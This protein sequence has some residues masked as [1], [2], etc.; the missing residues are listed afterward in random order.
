MTPNYILYGQWP[1]A[2]NTR[3]AERQ[4]N[5]AAIAELCGVDAS[6]VR[7]WRFSNNI[8]W[9]HLPVVVLASGL[10]FDLFI[11]PALL[12][13]RGDGGTGPVM[14][15][16][17]LPRSKSRRDPLPDLLAPPPAAPRPPRVIHAK[18]SVAKTESRPQAESPS[19]SPAAPAVQET[20]IAPA[21]E[22][23]VT[24]VPAVDAETEM[25]A[26]PAEGHADLPS[27]SAVPVEADETA[28]A[29]A[30]P[31]GD[32]LEAGRGE[33]ETTAVSGDETG[34]EG[35]G[36]EAIDRDEP[37][38]AAAESSA[39]PVATGAPT[40]SVA[41]QEAEPPAVAISAV[42]AEPVAEPVP[43]PLSSTQKLA[44]TLAPM[45]IRAT[46][47]QKLPRPASPALLD[48]GTIATGLVG[49]ADAEP[50]APA[51]KT[52]VAPAAA[53]ASPVET[54]GTAAA[55]IPSVP[56]FQPAPPLPE[57]RLAADIPARSI[58]PQAPLP[59]RAPSPKPAV[60]TAPPAKPAESRPYATAATS[61][62]APAPKS[63]TPR[64]VARSRHE[65]NAAA[66]ELA[67][68]LAPLQDTEATP[69]PSAPATETP[70][71]SDTAHDVLV[72]L[73]RLQARFVQ[74]TTPSLT[75]GP[76]LTCQ[77]ILDDDVR[78][79]VGGNPHFCGRPSIRGKSYCQEHAAKCF[80]KLA[81]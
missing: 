9:P 46:A 53:E 62:A 37:G 73:E 59:N 72:D 17:R 76:A 74:K 35:A 57:R 20:G 60:S 33:S 12:K 26:A 42:P 31:T 51:E 30:V 6:S 65:E 66:Q 1:D 24:T 64:P 15:P 5:T 68:L 54:G 13:D 44:A 71:P 70:S 58:T 79:R 69:A 18:P 75:V 21:G 38:D 36:L 4:L 49:R 28:D 7:R 16:Q 81:R 34:L 22:D 29:A 78:D 32:A 63:V 8:P 67:A 52:Q 61:Q 41:A 23:L 39:P 43:A 27:G 47:G 2:L 19:V 3:L 56:D 25:A 80:I 14:T 77:Y 45:I 50:E 55:P 40:I 48:A 11:P 10:P